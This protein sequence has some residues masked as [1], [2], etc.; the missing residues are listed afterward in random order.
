MSEAVA[1]PKWPGTPPL[2]RFAVW[3]SSQECTIDISRAERELGYRPVTTREE[4]LREMPVEP[5]RLRKY[6]RKW[7]MEIS[8][9]SLS[10]AKSTDRRQNTPLRLRSSSTRAGPVAV[11][12]GVPARDGR[13]VEADVGRQ[14]PPDPSPPVL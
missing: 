12:Q 14:A 5:T 11:H 4:G 13:V 3:V 1:P 10:S 7:P 8:S 9:P 6:S 2:T